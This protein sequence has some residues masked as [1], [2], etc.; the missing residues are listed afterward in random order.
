M[1]DRAKMLGELRVVL[2][3]VGSEHALV[4]GLAAGYHG[5]SRATI[6]VDLLV[7][8]AKLN[9]LARALE[10]RGYVIRFSLPDMIRVLPPGA[11]PAQGESIADLVSKDA[12]PVLCAAFT[13]TEETEVLGHRVH[14]VSRGAFVALKFHAAVSPKRRIED[15]YQ[16]I[17]DIGR[18]VSRRFDAEDRAVALRIAAQ[19]YPGAPAELEAIVEDL[20]NGRPVKL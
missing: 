6:D 10:A 5:R 12:N 17:V 15:R 20:K 9:K 4:G 16:D 1:D 8:G 11:D 3:E 2:E 18:V 7:P 19:M 13:A 14:V